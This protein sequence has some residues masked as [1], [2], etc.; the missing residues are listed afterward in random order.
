MRRKATWLVLAAVG[1]VAMAG[2]VDAVRRSSSHA[3][4]AR[5]NESTIDGLTTTAP[6]SQVTTEGV[7]TTQAAAANQAVATTAPSTQS[8]P[9]E[10]LP[11][12]ATGQ[13]R[14][15]L[16]VSD[17]VEALELRRVAGKPCHHGLSPI[18]FT[19]HDQSGHRVTLFPAAAELRKTVPTDFTDGFV[20]L[21]QIPYSEVC[22]PAG[23]FL[24]VATVGPYVARRTVPGKNLVCNHG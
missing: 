22:D 20:Q 14:L 21:M 12:C 9:S 23:S 11:S 13:L 10:R 4:S 19:V 7:A 6:S 2:V 15:T 17:G 18:G 24:A 1:V 5:P 3:E 8:I 16:T